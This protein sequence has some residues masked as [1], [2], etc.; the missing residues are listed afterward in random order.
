VSAAFE[1]LRNAAGERLDLA[2]HPA[3]ADGDA[4]LVIGHGVTANKDRAFLVALAE[5]VAAEGIAALR[6]SFSGNGE[7]EGRF[8]D[9]TITKEVADLGCVLDAVEASGPWR[10]AYAGHSM[11][12]AVGVLR[13]SEDPRITALV[14]LAGMVRTAQFAERKFGDQRPGASLMWDKPECPLSQTFLDDM[15]LIGSV[16]DR[17]PRIEVPWLL[18]H[19]DADT[20]VPVEDTLDA[21]RAAP[22][23]TTALLPGADHLFSGDATAQML[24]ETVPWLVERLLGS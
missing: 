19:G 10:V 6:V 14:S 24:D 8:E 4:L 23:A 5:A 15:R 11:G 18:V 13:A 7:S 2:F 1:N 16:L 20:V 3:G 21:A 22:N 12:G 17:A 9:S